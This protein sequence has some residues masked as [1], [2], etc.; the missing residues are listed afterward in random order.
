MRCGSILLH[1][2]SA[3]LALLGVT[4]LAPR[5]QAQ[6]P[7]YHE[8]SAQD[9]RPPTPRGPDRELLVLPILRDALGKV[10]GQSSRLG[11]PPHQ[12]AFLLP[13]CGNGREM[14]EG[15]VN[16][17]LDAL[18]RAYGLTPR[19]EVR[20]VGD[21]LDVRVDGYDPVRRLGWKVVGLSSIDLDEED[22]LDRLTC[23]TTVFVATPPAEPDDNMALLLEAIEWLDTQTDGI[24]VH[25][26]ALAWLR[27]QSATLPLPPGA[28][29]VQG[30]DERGVV[31][32][33]LEAASTWNID[34]RNLEWHERLGPFARQQDVLATPSTPL[35]APQSTAG[36][37]T[38]VQLELRV[39]KAAPLVGTVR[40]AINPS[41]VADATRGKRAT[42]VLPSTFDAASPFTIEVRL[43]PGQYELRPWLHVGLPAR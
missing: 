12:A 23:A 15:M 19:P 24:D 10:P 6:E 32:F 7:P 26:E 36:H 27:L 37:P 11:Y 40:Q 35:Q 30:P 1:V 21:R 2:A 14:L 41:G 5:L 13:G 4:R 31:R 34:S 39:V 29:G 33:H 18:F 16:K 43:A 42:F 9:L 20:L 28:A 22:E 25:H 38:I 3:M 8:P 17:P